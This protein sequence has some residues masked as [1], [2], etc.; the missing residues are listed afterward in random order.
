[1]SSA[2]PPDDVAEFGVYHG[3]VGLCLLLRAL[4]VGAGDSVAI[5]AFTCIAVSEAVAAA[6]ATSVY[7]DI[8]ADGLNMDPA[9]LRR[10]NDPRVN[11][12]S[13]QH[14]FG[15]PQTSR[16]SFRPPPRRG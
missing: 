4:G 7:V 13:V 10:T 8:E 12:V 15:I 5:Q 14:S 2:G 11:A 16:E 9:S 3:R 1:M 6:G